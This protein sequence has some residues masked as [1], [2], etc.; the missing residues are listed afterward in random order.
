[1]VHT[2]KVDVSAHVG[3]C[4]DP[5]MPLTCEAAIGNGSQVWFCSRKDFSKVRYLPC[6]S[7]DFVCIKH[8][9]HLLVFVISCLDFPGYIGLPEEYR[10]ILKALIYIT[11]ESMGFGARLRPGSTIINLTHYP[12]SLDFCYLILRMGRRKLPV[13]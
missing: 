10:S 1:M 8:S 4:I 2:I 5:A 7:F 6:D 13:F 11:F 12:V 3:H 9:S